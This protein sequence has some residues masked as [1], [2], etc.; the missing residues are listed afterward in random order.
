MQL[1]SISDKTIDSVALKRMLEDDGAG[2]LVTFE[3]HVRDHNDGKSVT[4]LAYEVFHA[5][6]QAEGERILEEAKKKFSVRGICV[7]HREGSLKIGDC[8]VWIGV[9]TTHRAEAFEAARYIIEAVKHRL[10]IWKKETYVDGS[11][12]WVNCSHHS[13]SHS[14]IHISE[15]DLS[16]Y[17]ARQM[18]LPEIKSEGQAKLSQAKIAIVGVGG[19][20]SSAALSLASAGIGT[21]GLI[22]FDTL[23]AS[24]LHRQ[25]IY[26]VSA[27]GKKKVSAAASQLRAHNP[28]ITI[29]E[30]DEKL[31]ALNAEGLLKDYDIVLDCTDNFETKYLLNDA[32]ILLD[33]YLIQA[34]IYKFEGQ[35]LTIDPTSPSGCLRCITPEPPT[36]GMVE[37]CSELGVLGT[38]PAIFGALQANEALKYVLGLT[39][40]S[41]DHILL[42]D[43]KDLRSHFVLR[44]KDDECPVCGKM[45]SI[46]SLQDHEKKSPLEFVSSPTEDF[47]TL[48]AQ[49]YLIDLREEDEGALIPS[50]LRLPFSQFDPE[51]LSV[52]K[53]MPVLLFC[54][55][56][57]RSL[58]AAMTLRAAGWDKAYSLQDGVKSLPQNQR[59]A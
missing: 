59:A 46:T 5:L 20:G 35:L 13:P 55:K 26:P 24:N 37:D 47:H 39:S 4:N 38:V 42:Y 54:A 27:I 32:A 7:T 16:D 40:R 52:S 19:L 34:S 31:T 45:P 1:F 58:K 36:K 15:S 30:Y 12:E 17:Y 25:M 57:L 9:T 23:E 2:A 41:S 50:T 49:F 48:A 22:E 18:A 56:G 10:P 29:V 51:R 33:K 21:I 11:H 14:S 8:A 28:L 43:L 3:G 44:Q 53:E 6:A